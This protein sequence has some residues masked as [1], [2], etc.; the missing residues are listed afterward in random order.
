MK[1][2]KVFI[3]CSI[4]YPFSVTA[5]SIFSCEANRVSGDQ[6]TLKINE[7]S[8][9]Y[10]TII[11]DRKNKSILEVYT[12]HGTKWETRY[13]IIEDNELNLVGKHRLQAD[14][15]SLIHFKLKEKLYSVVFAG[16]LGN[17]LTFGKCYGD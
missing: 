16:D 8:I 13:K 11:I 14:W 17:T 6:K 2:F 1:I 9:I 5:S 7:Y 15:V 4:F 12:E 10:P 3:I